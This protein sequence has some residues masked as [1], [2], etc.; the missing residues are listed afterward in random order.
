VPRTA[1]IVREFADGVM[2]AMPDFLP[3]DILERD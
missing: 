3:R 1:R 2:D